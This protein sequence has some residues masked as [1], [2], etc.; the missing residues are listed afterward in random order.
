MSTRRC[1]CLPLQT[2]TC[3]QMGG[4]PLLRLPPS[5]RPLPRLPPSKPPLP[6][7]TVQA[8]AA[9]TAAIQ[10]ALLLPPRHDG[11]HDGRGHEPL[12]GS[13][14]AD[15]CVQSKSRP[16]RTAPLPLPPLSAP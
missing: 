13:T 1:T 9:A 8:V 10:A 12:H 2:V 5:K 7:A 11:R 4:L 14:A 15:C 6:T 3:S 16:R